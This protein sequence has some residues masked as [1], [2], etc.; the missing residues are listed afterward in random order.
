MGNLAHVFTICTLMSIWK[1]PASRGTGRL[2]NIIS[3]VIILI[4]QP[5]VTPCSLIYS[6]LTFTLH[7]SGAFC[8]HHQEYS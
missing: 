3:V 7:V 6:L 5:D 4:N 1:L 8:T 2:K